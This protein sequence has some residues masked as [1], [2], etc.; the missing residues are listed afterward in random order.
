[1][2]VGLA[3][4]RWDGFT[5]APGYTTL[6]FGPGEP[7]PVDGAAMITAADTFAAAMASLAGNGVSLT[8]SPEIQWHDEANGD[9]LDVTAKSPAPTP[10]GGASSAQ[11]PTATGVVISW[12]TSG[13]HRGRHV[14]G[15][16]FVVPI[17]ANAYTTAGVPSAAAVS[18]AT[19][20]G[21]ALIG[22]S[23]ATFGIWCRPRPPASGIGPVE[24]GAWFPAVTCHV[25]SMPAVLRS[26]RD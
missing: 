19:G 12:T 13:I 17:N 22:A 10:H 5:G 8:C 9:L 3:T 26:R 25:P 18:A 2:P 24:A 14:R 16:T 23:G 11:G 4:I 21:T 7:D 20:A 6:A 1:M 15:R